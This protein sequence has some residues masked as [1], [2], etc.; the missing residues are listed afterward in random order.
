MPI[1]SM[2]DMLADALKRK[3]ALGYFEA[4]DQY[5]IE[6]VL[7]AAEECKSPIILG[8]GGVMMNQAWFGSGGLAELAAM[9]RV[10]A[11]RAKVPVAYLLNEVLTFGHIE[12]GLKAGFNTVMLDTSHLPFE[13]NIIQTREVVDIAKKY[14]ADV[15]G[16]C[17]PLPDASGTMGEHA[18]SK[19]THP[20]EALRFVTET[21]ICALSVAIGNEH[22]QTEGK[23]A[24]D[25]DLLGRL[26]KSVPLPLV[27]HG[28]T[29]FPDDCVAR[30]IELGVAKFNVGSILKKLYLESIHKSMLS[31]TDRPDFQELVGSHKCADFMNVAKCVVKDEVKRR[32]IVYQSVGKA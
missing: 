19:M 22:I 17:D 11:E 27:I 8:F 25:F 4:W 28:G 9:G 12:Q 21:G 18:G 15:E 30:A 5:S 10:V 16:E 23:S 7:E 2:R 29:G 13:E 32:L 3:Y 6:A 1:V 31:L 20:H 24:I 26:Q 14:G